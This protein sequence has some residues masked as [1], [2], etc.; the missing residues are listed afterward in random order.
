MFPTEKVNG[1]GI[2]DID[3]QRHL[4]QMEIQEKLGVMQYKILP[5]F[6]SYNQKIL[7]HLI[8]TLISENQG[9]EKSS[10]VSNLKK[11]SGPAH[12]NFFSVDLNFFQFVNWIFFRF[13]P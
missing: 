8:C 6:T 3:Q 12:L 5:V 10:S 11:I 7:G 1:S 2:Y 4:L 13:V 9:L